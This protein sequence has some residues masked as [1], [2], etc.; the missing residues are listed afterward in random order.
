MKSSQDS[1]DSITTD[2][3]FLSLLISEL[4]HPINKRKINNE[5]EC[6]FLLYIMLNIVNIKS[7]PVVSAS[8]S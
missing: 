7:A 3:L 4:P 5:D 2:V 1:E 8:Q 6:I